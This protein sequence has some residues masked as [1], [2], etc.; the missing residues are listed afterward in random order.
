MVVVEVVMVVEGDLVVCAMTF[1]RDTVSVVTRAVLVTTMVEEEE[2][3]VATVVAAVVMEA[4]AGMMA[5]VV[6][7]AMVGVMT[8]V[9]VMEEATTA[10]VVC[11][12]SS[13]TVPAV[14]E[15]RVNSLTKVVEEAEVVEWVVEEDTVLVEEE[16]VAL[17]YAT[18]GKL[19]TVAMATLVDFPTINMSNQTLCF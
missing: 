11:V 9:V 19:E 6:E 17:E 18:N 13:R 5:S 15:I 3:V 7:E 4:M 12:T 8:M 14:T 1:R 10:H 2:V 16:E